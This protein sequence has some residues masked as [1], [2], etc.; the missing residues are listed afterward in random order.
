MVVV[1]GSTLPI[2]VNVNDIETY[3]FDRSKN[4]KGYNAFHLHA[5]YDLL[6]HTYDDIIL[7]KTSKTYLKASCLIL[8]LCCIN[9]DAVIPLP[10]KPKYL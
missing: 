8:L 7:L 1:D 4:K 6:E 2:S 5:S 3:L 10:E 9:A